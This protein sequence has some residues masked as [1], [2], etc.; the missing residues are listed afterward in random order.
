M[1]LPLSQNCGTKKAKANT[2]VTPG[3]NNEKY[4]GNFPHQIFANCTKKIHCLTNYTILCNLFYLWTE[5]STLS[6][7]LRA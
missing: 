4:Y 1:S 7:I 3:A 2:K 5:K 6:W